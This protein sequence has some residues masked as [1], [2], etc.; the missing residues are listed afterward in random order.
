MK[1]IALLYCYSKSFS[2][3]CIIKQNRRANWIT[4]AK[5]GM[6]NVITKSGMAIEETNGKMVF[7]SENHFN[8]TK[9]EYEIIKTEAKKFASVVMLR[10]HY[11]GNAKGDYFW[12]KDFERI[13][14]EKDYWFYNLERP[15]YQIIITNDDVPA[16]VESRKRLIDKK[17]KRE[18]ELSKINCTSRPH[19]DGRATERTQPE[20]F[21]EWRKEMEVKSENA[22]KNQNANRYF[23]NKVEQVSVLFNFFV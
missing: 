3:L 6:K 11:R 15:V 8:F 23:A 5:K 17:V 20:A 9:E 2:Y 21:A 4:P 22:R 10:D 16:I 13:F 19:C 1:I 7:R 18:I 12:A 14:N